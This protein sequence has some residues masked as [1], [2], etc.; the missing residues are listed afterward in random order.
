MG[1]P[2]PLFPRFPARITALQQRH[3]K[4]C[5][6]FVSGRVQGVGFRF[7]AVTAAERAGVAGYV[8]NLAD[9]R[10]EVYALGDEDQLAALHR[11]LQVGP[12]FASVAAVQ[13][14]NAPVDRKYEGEFRIEHDR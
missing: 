6:F 12:R 2:A 14:E 11:E 7:F 1:L 4:A 8:R 3:S 10:V 9:G 13:A 5:R